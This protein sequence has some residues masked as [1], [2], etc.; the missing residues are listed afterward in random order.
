MLQE[1]LQLA[2]Q[3]KTIEMVELCE[4]HT[5]DL[6]RSLISCLEEIKDTNSGLAAVTSKIENL[7]LMKTHEDVKFV[8]PSA[9]EKG[10]EIGKSIR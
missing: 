2:I 4:E 9:I 5:D 6:Y 7:F 8:F 10:I 3:T 1:W